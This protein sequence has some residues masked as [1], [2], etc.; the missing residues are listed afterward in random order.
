MQRSKLLALTVLLLFASFAVAQSKQAELELAN[1]T[2]AVGYWLDP[3]TG[4]MWAAKD[5]GLDV[6]WKR[7]VKYCHELR[8]AGYSD[9]RLGSLEEEQ[10]I[11]ERGAHSPGYNPKSKWHDGE[12][13]NFDI[14]GGIF[15]TGTQWTSS[16]IPNDRGKPS[17]YA[18]RFDFNEGRPFEGDELWFNTN[19]RALCVRIASTH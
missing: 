19:K 1:N 10:A 11:Y 16:R 13:M 9:W 3:S 5:N 8:L 17:G 18:W 6:S 2:Q 7:A 12:P 4:L 15:I 14:K